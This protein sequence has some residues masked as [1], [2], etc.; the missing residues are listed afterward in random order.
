[1]ETKILELHAQT[2]NS[3]GKAEVSSDGDF[4]AQRKAEPIV[5]TKMV[6]FPIKQFAV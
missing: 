1:M 5:L 3:N 2:D 4:G 6:R